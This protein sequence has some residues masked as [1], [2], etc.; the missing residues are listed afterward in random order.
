VSI[1][2]IISGTPA[3]MSP[4]Q[5]R[6]D[7]LDRRTDIFALG[8]LLYE[9][10]TGNQAFSGRTGG[11]IIEAILTR[12]P[13]PARTVNPQIPT[14]LEEIINKCLDKDRN[15]R[16]PNAAAVRSDLQQL[17]RTSESGQDTLSTPIPAVALPVAS[18]SRRRFGW[19][20]TVAG[21]V[22]LVACL[23][24]GA[25]LYNTRRAHALTQTDTIVLA[26]FIN[27]TGDPIFD[28]TLR[29]GLAAQL[30]QSPFLSLV[31]EQR[32]QQTLRLMGKPTDSKLSPAIAGDVCQRAGSKAYLSG[33]ISRIG[34]QYVIGVSAVNCQTGDYLAQEQIT[35]NGKENVLRALG[36]ASTQLRAK[37]GE[38]LK[39]VEKLD[40]PI[41][42]A[43]TPSLE[44]LQAY[45][46][47]R[48]TLQAKAD[49]TAAVPLFQRS[50][51]LDPN[52][53][54][55]YATL[56]TTFHNLGEKN[57]AAE[58]TRKAYELRTHVSEWEKF[59]IESHYYHFV[60]GDLEKARQVYELWAQIYPREQVPPTNLGVIYQTLGQHDKS[61]AEFREALR[62]SPADSLNFGNL[63][64]G[65]LHLNRL[66]EARSAANEALAKNLDSA[67]LRVSL[68]QLGF[69]KNDPLERAQQVAWSTG[70]PGKE[71]L[72]LYLEAGTAAYSG[73]LAAARELSGRAATSAANAGEIEMAAGCESAAALWEALYGNTS[74][75]R[76]LAAGTLAQSNGR[77]AEY[78]AAFALAVIGDSA[79][80]QALADDLQKRFPQDTVVRLNYLPTLHAQLDLAVPN[81]G[82]KAVNALA[83][84]S[85]Y[86]LGV[87]GSSTFW[88]N[89]Y[90][91]YVR[92]EAYLAAQQ[93]P[94][95]A[96][97]FQRILDWPGVVVN[98]PIAALAHLGLARSYA[99]TGDASKSKAAYKDFLKL[100]KDADPDVPILIA[101]KG[102]YAKLP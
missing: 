55:A 34:S 17:K 26:D 53:A 81:G 102:E 74:E 12:T 40:T 1:V 41:E 79:R 13:T 21:A 47:G 67:D 91:V 15:L 5:V 52:F 61:L 2:G 76:E 75:A 57:L 69:L 30:Q 20:A 46:L 10:S 100:W 3:Y 4:E 59:Y 58:N 38:S 6:G 80:A 43:T 99:V 87:P 36:E 22:L 64:L 25:W 101:A 54:M 88:T 32:I 92:G 50:I 42:Q 95:A 27:K 44:A 85:P 72:M 90:P 48:K 56:G 73:R 29:Q 97:E 89:L 62:L 68:Y 49:F 66:D 93:G 98:E 39:T 45:S 18:P 82:A 86:E 7:E 78:V 35:A 51:Q 33:S 96:A 94:Q 65:Y 70:K 9:M 63:V 31:S 71:N 16:Y 60:T 77:D 24:V 8:L 14:Q 37:L 84:T 83:A 11:A 19:K 28:D 23:G